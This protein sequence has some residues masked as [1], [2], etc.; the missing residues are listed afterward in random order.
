M[1]D[2]VVCER[3]FN[4][5]IDGES[6][7]ILAQ[8]MKPVPDGSGWR[9]AYALTWPNGTVRRRSSIG[10]DSSQALILAFHAVSADLEFAPWPVRWFDNEEGDVGLPGFEDPETRTRVISPRGCR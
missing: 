4:T 1:T 2:E 3:E 8:L 7:P 10:V 6:L 9:C 5:V